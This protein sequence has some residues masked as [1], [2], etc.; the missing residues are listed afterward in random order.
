M[1]ASRRLRAIGP[2]MMPSPTKPIFSS[3]AM[4][5]TSRGLDSQPVA[6]LQR[7]RCLRRQLVAVDEVPTLRAGLATIRARRGVPAP[8]RDQRVAH[9]GE[10][11]QLAHHAVAAAPAARPAGA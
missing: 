7:S 8:L 1:P 9:L 10:R 11:L 5:A 3:S 2:P 4:S 6:G